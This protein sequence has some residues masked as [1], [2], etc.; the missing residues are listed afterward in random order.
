MTLRQY[1][2][3]SM[4]K[5]RRVAGLIVSV[6]GFDLG[7]VDTAEA[8]SVADGAAESLISEKL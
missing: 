8:I 1:V 7:E 3:V 6:V 2:A 5:P 4:K